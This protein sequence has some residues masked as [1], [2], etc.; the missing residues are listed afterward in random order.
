V[1]G[2]WNWTMNVS[3]E[4]RGAAVMTR[5]G[6]VAIDSDGI[7][8]FERNTSNA[9]IGPLQVPRITH[10]VGFWWSEAG[11][12]SLRAEVTC[13]GHG[14]ASAVSAA[15]TTGFADRCAAQQSNPA[16]ADSDTAWLT[17]QAM[18]IGRRNRRSNVTIGH[19]QIR[20]TA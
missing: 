13:I 16:S 8:L 9:A 7:P 4:G 11:W 20:R 2:D 12:T 10:F 1:S 15:L 17:S 14:A 6:V 19:L 3:G 5:P 18:A